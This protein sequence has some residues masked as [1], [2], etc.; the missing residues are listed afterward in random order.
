MRQFLPELVTT[1]AR[2]GY[3]FGTIWS[4]FWHD[5]VTIS[6]RLR[7]NFGTTCSQ[8][9]HDLVTILAW[10]GHNICPSC[11]LGQIFARLGQILARLRQTV[12]RHKR[13]CIKYIS[14]FRGD[15]YKAF[16]KNCAPSYLLRVELLKLWT[17]FHSASLRIAATQRENFLPFLSIMWWI[18]FLFSFLRFVLFS[19]PF[20][21]DSSR[22]YGIAGSGHFHLPLKC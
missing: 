13:F 5:L 22:R 4:Q 14:Y 11:E 21:P 9:S 6:T 16:S 20:S 1:L 17:T 15:C 3:N 19:F 7:H 18:F 12:D 8:F 10:L 2:L